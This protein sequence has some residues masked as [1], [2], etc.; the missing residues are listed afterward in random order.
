ML[1][2][3][4]KEDLFHSKLDCLGR[5]GSNFMTKFDKNRYVIFTSTIV[6][7]KEQLSSFTHWRCP[8]A[9]RSI[10]RIPSLD[11]SLKDL[12]HLAFLN[13]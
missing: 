7:I 3:L 12:C 9:L 13:V 4:T 8:N 2:F 5:I 10:V 6:L 11:C 1:Y